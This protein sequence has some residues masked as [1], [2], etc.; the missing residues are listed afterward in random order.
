M[1]YGALGLLCQLDGPDDQ[2]VAADC[3]INTH[4]MASKLLDFEIL[5]DTLSVKDVFTRRDDSV[6]SLMM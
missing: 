5:S 6:F 1:A 3:E 2:A 4:T